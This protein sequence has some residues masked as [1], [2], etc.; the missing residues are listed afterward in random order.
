MYVL[1]KL[2]KQGPADNVRH[3]INHFLTN[4]KAKRVYAADDPVGI[5]KARNEGS[6]IFGNGGEVAKTPTQSPTSLSGI[7]GQE[8]SSV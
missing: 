4:H 3:G 2:M 8:P 1:I 7:F 6:D 5:Y